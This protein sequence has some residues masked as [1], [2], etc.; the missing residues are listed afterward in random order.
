MVPGVLEEVAHRLGEAQAR[1]RF[2]F[3]RGCFLQQTDALQRAAEGV[4]GVRSVTF[5]RLPLLSHSSSSGTFDRPGAKAGPDGTVPQTG[6]VYFHNVRENFFEVMEIPLLLG[7]TFTAQDNLRAPKVAVVNQTFAREYF[8]EG[9]P[10]GKRFGFDI[11]KP[12]EIEIIGLV[13]DA[14]YTSQRDETPA[15]MYRSWLQTPGATD[16]MT[17][18]V[19]T[20]G[21]P[22]SVVATIRQAVREVEPDL[23][24][25]NIK[26]Q[27]EQAGETLSM[28]RLFAKLMSLFGVLAQQLASIGLYGHTRSGFGWRWARTAEKC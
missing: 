19:R 3:A 15:T 13:K 6:E 1:A 20:T 22:K 24:L 5:S 4:P 25:N 14:K 16:S 8:P 9:N 2:G 18:E 28:E 11:A 26:T 17:F 7:R 21:D 23:P 10:I 27:I 12:D